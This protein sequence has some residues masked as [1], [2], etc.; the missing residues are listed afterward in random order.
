VRPKFAQF[1]IT[2]EDGLA[3]GPLDSER[4]EPDVHSIIGNAGSMRRQ[5][6][7]NAVLLSY[8]AKRISAT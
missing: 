6:N 1:V 7:I 4:H 3:R 2:V 8:E 5:P